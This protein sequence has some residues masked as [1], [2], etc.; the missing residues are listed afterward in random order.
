MYIALA[1]GAVYT[2]TTGLRGDQ[3][4]MD[5]CPRLGYEAIKI[6]PLQF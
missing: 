4:E 5:I 6:Q 3:T 1:D 2:G